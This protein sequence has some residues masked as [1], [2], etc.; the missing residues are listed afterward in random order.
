MRA[1]AAE[2]TGATAWVNL[3]SIHALSALPSHGTYSA[4]KAAVIGLEVLKDL[5]RLNSYRA[6]LIP[7]DECYPDEGSSV[8]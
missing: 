2:A 5:E 8:G 1:R 7:T 4:S 3:L 6:I